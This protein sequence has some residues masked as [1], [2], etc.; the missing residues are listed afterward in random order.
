VTG[1]ER[2]CTRSISHHHPAIPWL[3]VPYDSAINDSAE[4]SVRDERKLRHQRALRKDSALERPRLFTMKIE[5]ED[6]DD[7]EDDSHMDEDP[8]A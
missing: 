7:D 5:N 6:E 2:P 4:K 8:P 1:D 3:P